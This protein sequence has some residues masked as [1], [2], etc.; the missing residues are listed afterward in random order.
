M[1]R[2]FLSLLGL[3]VV[4]VVTQRPAARPERCPVLS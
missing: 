1:V 2:R 4:S 3:F